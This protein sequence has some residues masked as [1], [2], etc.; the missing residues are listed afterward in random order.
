MKK[1][2]I[3]YSLI[4]GEIAAI[5]FVSVF[6][7][8]VAPK[9][10]FLYSWGLLILLPALSLFGIWISFLIGKK[11][12]VIFQIAKYILSGIL[13]TVIDLSVIN[14][15]MVITG[16]SAGLYY[17]VFKA[18]SFLA[19]TF[20]KFVISKFW[21]FEKF[22]KEKSLKETVQFFIV[23][24]IG[25]IINVGAASFVNEVI[26]PQYGLSERL[27]GNISAIGAAFVSFAWNFVGY[28]F[29]VFKK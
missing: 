5:Y 1:Q 25:L 27:W 8:L 15:L 13:A 19:A 4:I 10:I 17:K 3:I 20:V 16:V 14:L 29:I 24:L 18:F 22:E 12:L 23:T 9:F 11:F 2:D 6:K 28:K 7:E 26:G 21:T